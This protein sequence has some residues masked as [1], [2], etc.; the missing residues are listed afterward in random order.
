[1]PHEPDA[2]IQLSDCL[3]AI[4]RFGEARKVLEHLARREPNNKKLSQQIALLGNPGD[5]GQKLDKTRE[6]V[7][8]QNEAIS[9]SQYF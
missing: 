8:Q 6:A 7:R 3:I 1:V 5:D 4:Q 9:G 2:Y